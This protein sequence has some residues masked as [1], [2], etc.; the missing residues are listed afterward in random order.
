MGYAERVRCFNSIE[1]IPDRP[2]RNT[3]SGTIIVTMGAI[4]E[5]FHLVFSY[6]RDVTIDSRT[7]GLILTMP[8]INY[9]Y[10]AG[11]IRLNFRLRKRDVDLVREF[12]RTNNTEVF[13]NKICR[14]RYEFIKR[15]FIPGEGEITR[16]NAEGSTMIIADDVVDDT[17]S[18]TVEYSTCRIAVLSSGG[19]E[20]L[21]SY[22]IL[23]ELGKEV[24][25]VFFNESGGHWRTAKTSYDMISRENP[26][27]LKIWSN[28][29]RF[30]T[31]MRDRITALDQA[32]VRK[33]ADTY[34]IRLFIFPVYVMAALPYLVSNGISGLVMGN[35]F[36][37]PGEMK[38]FHGIIHHYGVYDQ[39]RDFSERISG[40]FRKSGHKID[41]Y[42]LLYPI[43]GYVVENILGHRYPDLFSTQ[44][45]CH[46]CHFTEEEIAPCGKCTKCAGILLFCAASSLDY[47]LIG[48]RDVTCNDIIRMADSGRM[49]LD[50]DE[51]EHM[52]SRVRG[53]DSKLHEHVEGVHMLPGEPVPF[54]LVPEELRPGLMGIVGKYSSGIYSLASENWVRRN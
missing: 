51:L 31:F 44:R 14:R 27:T 1:V 13:V 53:I 12:V 10:F 15:D 43:S 26:E 9:A 3:V 52:I 54:S 50:P 4:T 18:E 40:Y 38:P 45:S 42:S 46:S 19:K 36:D 34:P 7:A 47:G 2:G 28:V 33:R 22:G 11:E 35:E 17:P 8:V 48:Y 32:M 16:E 37:D 23:K 6:N 24:F 49:R 29:D 25:P 39:S 21:L 30:Y 41:L 20:S 5:K